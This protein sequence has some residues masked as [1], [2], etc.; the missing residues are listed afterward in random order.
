MPTRQT[1]AE[2]AIQARIAQRG[3]ITFAEFMEMALYGRGGYYS[4]GEPFGAEGDFFTSPLAHPA[5]GALLAVQME[6]VWRLMGE[7]GRFEVLELGAGT[8][9][10]ANDVLSYMEVWSP[11][12]AK[13]LAYQACDGRRQPEGLDPRVTWERS[14]EV[15]AQ[16][17]GCIISNEFFDAL[18]VHVVEM[19]RKGLREV[20]VAAAHG[21]FGEE[22]AEPST[23]ELAARLK[24]WGAELK[25]GY[26][27]E[28][29]LDAEVRMEALAKALTRG[30]II[31]VDYGDEAERL[32]IP[33][34]S[35]GTLTAYHR[36][37]QSANPLRRAGEQD[38]TAHVNFSGLMAAGSRGGAEPVTLMAQQVFLR[39]LGL[40]AVRERVE[41][42]GLSQREHDVNVMAMGELMRPEGLGGFRVLVQAK[43]IEA[44]R[45]LCLGRDE[46]VKQ[47]VARRIGEL[48]PPL[49]TAGHVPLASGKYPHLGG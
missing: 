33:Q 7:P 40:K 9:R 43:G 20:Y 29:C 28:I 12:C 38:L 4:A 27:G 49:V 41:Q 35:R 34:R 44:E 15:P 45:L 46:A 10:L 32:F 48:P 14:G 31:S 13:A 19:T 11:M 18:P 24:A 2:A 47:A 21:E 37:A 39:E 30:V 6:Q 5:F 3:R 36:H 25:P 8:G 42:A 1:E 17:A 16:I 26:R 23:P 22:L